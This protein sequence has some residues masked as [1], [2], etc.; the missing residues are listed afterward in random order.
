MGVFKS[1]RILPATVIISGLFIFTPA[2]IASAQTPD[3]TSDQSSSAVTTGTIQNGLCN[4][5]NLQ[6]S[7]QTCNNTDQQGVEKITKVIQ[8]LINTL[9][10]IVGIVAVVMIMIGGLRYITSGGSDTSVTSAKNT[11]LYAIIGLIIVALSQVMVRFVIHKVT[12]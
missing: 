1:L 2:A 12:E 9:S 4:G 3:P 6:I 7:D 11:I 8:D 10:L 5:A